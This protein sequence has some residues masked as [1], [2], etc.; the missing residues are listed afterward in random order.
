MCLDILDKP[1]PKII[2]FVTEMTL[3]YKNAVNINQFLKG[4]NS[5]V[6]ILTFYHNMK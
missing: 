4:L 1:T 2:N 6:F 3:K 5:L